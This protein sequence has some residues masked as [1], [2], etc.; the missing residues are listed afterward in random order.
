MD[1]KAQAYAVA[2]GELE[3]NRLRPDQ[4]NWINLHLTYTHG[5][6]IVSAPANVQG[7][8][9]L[10]AFN[11]QNIPATGPTTGSLPAPSFTLEHPQIYYGESSP[12]YSIVDT[13]QAEIDGPGT[14][15]DDSS[16]IHYDGPGGIKPDSGRKT[17][18]F[19][20]KFR[21]K[22]LPRS[23]DRRRWVGVRECV[24]PRARA[25]CAAGCDGLLLERHPNPDKAMSDG[26]QSLYP[27]QLEKLVKQCRL[28]APVVGRTVA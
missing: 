24:P 8:G 26:A 9:G 14:N 17:L 15:K 12:T 22:N 20:L 28:I 4:Q 2:E 19:A 23:A 11:V 5:N 7:P 25:S 1:G 13:K 10:P 21:G 18:L 6:G 3:L 16:T 27:E